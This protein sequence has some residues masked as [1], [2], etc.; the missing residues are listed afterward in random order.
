MKKKNPHIGSSL[1]DFLK[2]EGVLESSR[3]PT[4]AAIE[5]S[6][7]NWRWRGVP[8]YLRSGKALKQRLSEVVIQFRCPPHLMFPLPPG[9]TLQCNR[10]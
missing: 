3:T 4:Y 5:L 9:V 7:D 10:N 1:D 6:I 8:F 2:E